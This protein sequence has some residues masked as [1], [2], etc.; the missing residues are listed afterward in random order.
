MDFASA[1]RS[2]LVLWGGCRVLG[3]PDKVEREDVS[4]ARLVI[5]ALRL[6]LRKWASGCDC[7][8]ESGRV[9]VVNNGEDDGV[10]AGDSNAGAVVVSCVTRRRIDEICWQ[11]AC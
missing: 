9:G 3:V 2:D 6:W 7:Q 11:S 8:A 4:E 5:E 10:E 1:S